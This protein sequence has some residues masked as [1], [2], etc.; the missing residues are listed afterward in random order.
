MDA[1]HAK[2]II[3]AIETN[4]T[5]SPPNGIDWICMS[6]KA[7]TDIVLTAGNEIKIVYPQVGINPVDFEHMDYEHYYV[8]PMDCEEQELNTELCKQ[9]IDEHPSWKLSVQMHKILGIP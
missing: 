5:L 8:Q 1:C 7:N 9:F 6:P 2:G 3:I 4:G